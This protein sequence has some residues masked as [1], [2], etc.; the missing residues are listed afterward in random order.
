[1]L[2][3]WSRRLAHRAIGIAGTT[4][5]LTLSV[6]CSD[7]PD[8]QPAKADRQIVDLVFH[9][10]HVLTV[11]EAFSVH[12]VLVVDDGKV[13]ASG[14]Q[15]LL[16]IYEGDSTI[17]L[18]GNTLMPGFND[19]HTHLSG[20]ARRYIDLNKVSS[21]AQIQSLV[22]AKAQVLGPGE[23]ITGY[24]W[25]ED[26][27][28][29]QRKP[30]RYDL[31]D[32]APNNPVVL[33]RA[34]AHSAVAS[35]LALAA[36]NITA[37]TPDPE[38]GVIERGTTGEPSGI[39]RERHSLV[40]DL[41]PPATDEE[42]ASS[43]TVNLNALL[44]MGITSITDAQKT[45]DEYRRWQRVYV[46]RALPLPRAKLQFQWWNPEAITLLRKEVGHGDDWL[47]IGPIKIFVDG[48][49]TGPAAYTREPYRNQPNYRGYLN[50]PVTE[51]T[52]QIDEIHDAGLQMGIHA[53]GDAAIELVVKT[54]VQTLERNPRENHRHYLN[55][56]SMR[57]PQDTMNK[58]A[59]HGIHIT[60]Q[61]N[62]TY[63]LEGRYADNLDGWRL[64]HNNPLRGPMDAG[65]KVALSS[66][67]LPIGPMVGLYAAT[68]RKGM[69]GK[70]YGP[71]E[72][73]TLQEALRGY[74]LTSAFINFDENIKGSLEAGKYADMIVLPGN[75]LTT[76]PE[77][78]L[79]V[80][81]QQT[82]LQGELVYQR[83]AKGAQTQQEP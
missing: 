21:I 35:S 77:E 79:A 60:Q 27:L 19:S 83:T 32:A 42:L 8:V 4:A 50:M 26:E 72:A 46:E 81:V 34:G 62:F 52:R 22:R 49:F 47:K 13:V 6:A 17:D 67:I 1:M 43:L 54:L 9:N 48:G 18:A 61:P 70:V 24:G 44:S 28:S 80:E 41:V 59:K 74:T 15:E 69:S 31:D 23:W 71:D 33:T 37:N 64:A 65:I 76:P 55:H 78:L 2:K 30:N 29:E 38:G 3:M 16:Q 58:M 20:D 36:A 11:D 63:T 82:Y 57:P 45:P 73:I 10:G 66:D 51:L 5:A 75:L 56:F 53:I 68:T 25:S 39:I 40:L 7:A 12:Q 14:T